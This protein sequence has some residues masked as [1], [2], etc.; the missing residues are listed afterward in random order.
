MFLKKTPHNG[1]LG[2]RRVMMDIHR[3]VLGLNGSQE[4]RGDFVGHFVY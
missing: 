3:R 1:G 2:A 4:E